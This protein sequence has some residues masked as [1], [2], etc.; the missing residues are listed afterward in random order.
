[1]KETIDIKS[2]IKELPEKPGVYQFYGK[3]DVLLYIGK[4]K[5]LKKRVGSYFNRSR[6]SYNKLEVLEKKIIDIRYILVDNESDALLLENN[7]IK[8]NKPRYNVLLK[9]DKTFPW[10]CIRKESFP[11]VYYTRKTTNDGS[12]YFG[13]YTSAYMVKLLIN[14]IRQLFRLR[15]C[16]YNLDNENIKKGK[17]KRCLEF[18]LGNCNAPCEGLQSESDYNLSIQQIREILRGNLQQVILYLNNL[19]LIYAESYKYEEAEIILRKKEIIEKYKA[20]STIVNSRIKDVEV[21]SYLEDE[22]SVFVNFIKLINGAIIQ[23]Y[24]MELIKKIDEEPSNL[25]GF[26]IFE[27]RRRLNC[28][29]REIIV[30]FKPD[31]SLKNVV[32]TIPVRGDKRKLLELSERNV[33][34]FR[35]DKYKANEMLKKKREDRDPIN[36]LKAEL[37]L[38]KQPLHIE[39]IDISNIQGS[40]NVA[41][42]VVFKNGRPI[43]QEYRHYIIKSFKGQNDF[44]SIGEIVKRRIYYYI[45]ESIKLPDLI[46][47][48]GGKGQL[49]AAIQILSEMNMRAEIAIISIAKRLEEIYLPGDPIPLYLDKNSPALHLLQRIRN[50]A[51]RF[52]ISFHRKKRSESMISSELDKIKG[53]GP[54]TRDKI[55]K[56]VQDI[57]SIRKMNTDE[58]KNFVGVKMAV[59]IHEYFKKTNV[60]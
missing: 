59:I 1:M 48:D 17:Y 42:C 32:F 2:K 21:Y 53:I 25:L 52:G 31:I 23:A 55:L 7:L 35:F 37:R 51:H 8:E 10:I 4:A 24:N 13:P 14:M 45:N 19:M 47:I 60:S 9:D 49:N 30:P 22:K 46:V 11:R 43:K 54:K 38:R 39:C 50:E 56:K 44:A 28:S 15:T 16:N 5:N 33:K 29:A 57:D 3:D 58:L 6:L 12:E 26:A 36:Y 20:K 18:H 40:N 41:S 34:A 27:I